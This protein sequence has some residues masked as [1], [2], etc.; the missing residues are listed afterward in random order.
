MEFIAEP[1]LLFLDEPTSGLDSAIAHSVMESVCQTSRQ[2]NITSLAVLHSPRWATLQ[3]F[4]KVV[5]FASGGH[6]VYAG[7]AGEVKRYFS[8]KFGVFF[9]QDNNPA[10]ILIDS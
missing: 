9:D 3:L 6:C 4:D 2:K 1:A 8:E 7:P 5:L 10:D